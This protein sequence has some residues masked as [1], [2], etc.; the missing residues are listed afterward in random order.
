MKRV[1]YLTDEN[2]DEFVENSVKPV[3]VDFWAPWCQPCKMVSPIL[4][5]ISEEQ[6][7]VIIAKIDIQDNPLSA[8][9]CGIRSIPTMILF[10]DNEKIAS[11]SGAGS[12]DQIK[13]FIN[14][15]K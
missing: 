2:F 1:V 15:N 11:K 12:K 13:N 9:K 3:L 4:D 8:Q 7:E 5:E 10:K 6:E 14:N